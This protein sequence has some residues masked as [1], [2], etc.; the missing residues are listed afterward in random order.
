[1]TKRREEREEEKLRHSQIELDLT[2]GGYRNT[3]RTTEPTLVLSTYTPY[4][5][6]VEGVFNERVNQDRIPDL[7]ETQLR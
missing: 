5:V 7:E 2:N 3:E 6:P 4:S 1:M